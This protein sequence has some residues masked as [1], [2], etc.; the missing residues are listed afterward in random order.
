MMNHYERT[1]IRRWKLLTTHLLWVL[2]ALSGFQAFAQSTLEGCVNA[3][4]GVD[5]DLR[6][7]LL[8]FGGMSG[9]A[10]TEDWFGASGSGSYVIDTSGMGAFKALLQS[11]SVSRPRDRNLLFQRGMRVPCN[12]VV[13]GRL[14]HSATYIREWHAVT[15]EDQT[16]FAVNSNANHYDATTW[17]VGPANL[18]N[19]LDLIDAYAHTRRTGNSATTD[20]WLFSG[21]SSLVT[22][23]DWHI[24][25]EIFRSGLFYNYQTQSFY[26]FGPHKGHTAWSFYSNGSVAASGDMMITVDYEIGGTNPVAKMYIWVNP[27]TLPGGSFSSYNLLAN[28]VFNFTGVFQATTSAVS[29]PL[30]YGYAE[31]VPLGGISVACA[32]SNKTA[33]T[34]GPPLGT[35]NGSLAK[36]ANDYAALQF[37]EVGFNLT[38]LKMDPGASDPCLNGLG[39]LLIKRRSSHF[40]DA[41]LKDFVEP[42]RLGG[43]PLPKLAY[44]NPVC[45]GESLSLSASPVTGATYSWSGP[46]GFTSNLQNP[47]IP[48]VTLAAIG[49][50]TCNVT[51]NGCTNSTIINVS[52]NPS[53][54]PAIAGTAA[55][56]PGQDIY[57]NENG[58]GGTSWK[59]SGPNG[60]NINNKNFTL[61]N[62]S[63][64]NTGHYTVT[65]TGSNGCTS[66]AVRNLVKKEAMAAATAASPVVCSG[67]NLSLDETFGDA[68]SWSWTGP[69]GFASTIKNPVVGNIPESGEGDYIVTIIDPDGCL[70]SD[71]INIKVNPTP[72][73]PLATVET[74]VCVNGNVKL[75]ASEQHANTSF[76]WS[77]PSGFTSNEQNPVICAATPSVNGIYTVTATTNGCTS[78]PTPVTV[79]V[80]PPLAAISITENSCQP[81]DGKI[82]VGFPTTLT[83]SVQGGKSPYSYSWAN[84]LGSGAV[85]TVS[86]AAT[87]AYYVTVTDNNGCTAT[88]QT[89]VIVEPCIELSNNN[90]DDDGDGLIDCFDPDCILPPFGGNIG[91]VN[92]GFESNFNNWYVSGS[93]T[94]TNDALSGANAALL[95]D[96]GDGFN[97]IFNITPGKVYRLEIWAKQLGT[98][99]ARF[100]VDWLNATNTIIG[101]MAG[102]LEPSGSYEK[103]VLRGSS[104]GGAVKANVWAHTE[105]EVLAYFDDFYFST[106]N[107]TQPSIG[108]GQN[109]LVNGGFE[110]HSLSTAFPVF[111]QGNPAALLM[112]GEAGKVTDWEPDIPGNYIFYVNDNQSSVNNPDGNY[113]IWMP[114]GDYSLSSESLL[115][116]NANLEDGR[117]YTVSFYAAPWNIS[118]GEDGLP[119]GAPATQDRGQISLEFLYSGDAELH[120]KTEWRIQQSNSWSNLN[121]QLLTYNFT[122]DSLQPLDRI[123]LTVDGNTGM[124]IDGVQLKEVVNC[125]PEVCGNSLDDDGDGLTDCADLDCALSV[126]HL[127]TDCSNSVYDVDIRVNGLQSANSF[128]WNDVAPEA[129]WTFENTTNDVSGNSH[130]LTGS[131][132]SIQ[133]DNV[134]F[135]EGKYSFNFNGLTRLRYGINNSF[136]ENPGFSARTVMFWIKPLNLTGTKVLFEHGGATNG[137]A[138]R[139]NGNLLEAAVRNGG[140]QFTT[141]GLTIPNDGKWHHVAV[142]FNNGVLKTYLDGV[143]GTPVTASFTSV[144]SDSD[145]DGIGARNGTDAF[146]HSSVFYYTGRMD[147][148]RIQFSALTDQQVFDIARNDGDRVNLAA[149][150]Y[151]LTVTHACPVTKTINITGP[152]PPAIISQPVGFTECTGGTQALLVNAF[153]TD[154]TYQWQ[155]S[156][157]NVIF[158]DIAGA[159]TASFVPPSITAGTQYYR[160]IVIGANGCGSSTSS[161]ATVTVVGD[162]VILSAPSG[163]TA[164]LGSQQNLTVTAQ[165][166]IGALSYQWQRSADNVNFWDIPGANLA[167]YMPLTGTAGETW[168]RVVVSSGGGGCG[169]A[170]SASTL[171]T[172]VNGPT[173]VSQPVGYT[174]CY[175]TQ[176]QLAVQATGGTPF[177]SY[178]WQSSFD[179]INFTNI[180]GATASSYLSPGTNVGATYFRVVLSA[181]GDACGNTMSNTITVN[182]R[183]RVFVTAG[184]DINLC[185]GMTATMTATAFGNGPFEYEWNQGLGSG[186]VKIV[187]PDTNTV[188]T[189]TATDIAGCTIT[190]NVAVNL[191]QICVED[192]TNGIDDDGDGLTDCEDP[193]CYLTGMPQ[194][195]DDFYSTCPGAPFSEQ[196]S[197]N[198]SNLQ[199]P[200]FS[201]FQK[202]AKGAVVINNL[203]NF[204]YT[205]WFNVCTV[206]SF[207]YQVCNLVTGCCNTATVYLTLGNDDP[208]QFAGVPADI[209][210]ACDDILPSPPVVFANDTCPGVFITFSETSSLPTVDACE[211]Y[212]ITRTWKATDLCGNQGIA[213]QIITVE[214]QASPEIFRVYTLTNGKKLVAGVS[215]AVSHHWKNVKFP[216]NF[217]EKPLLLTQLVSNNEPSAASVQQRN[218]LNDGFQIRLREEEASNGIH[219]GEQVAWLA[220][221][222]GILNDASKLEAAMALDVNHNSKLLNF[223]Q[224]FSSPP[225]FVTVLQT[226]KESDPVTVRYTN[227]TNSSI[228]IFLQ[229]EKSLDAETNHANENL[230]YLAFKTGIPWTDQSG[231]FVAETGIANIDT[232]WTTV[233]LSGRFTKPVVLFGGI[234]NNDVG[235]VTVRVR[236]VT[237]NSFEVR[238]L[239]WTYQDGEHA[240]E[241]VSYIV[242]EGSVSG[243]TENYCNPSATQLIPGVNLFVKDNCDETVGLGYSLNI[244]PTAS[245]VHYHRSWSVVD[246]CGNLTEITRTDTCAAAAVQVKALLL[247]PL[248]G[249]ENTMLMSDA[250]SIGGQIPLEEPFSNLGN[251][252]HKG[253]GGGETI[254]SSVLNLQGSQ[255]VVDWILAE[256]RDG[257][258]PDSVLETRSLLLLRNGNVISVAGDSI[259]VFPQLQEGD[260]YVALRHRNH[261][262]LMNAQPVYL[263]TQAVP[264]LDFRQPDTEVNGG[265]GAGKMVNGMR[266]MWP[267]DFNGDRK[268]VYQGPGNDV[269]SLLSRVISDSGN[270]SSLANYIVQGYYR[271]D[272]NFDGKVIFQGPNNDRSLLLYQTILSHPGNAGNL[273]NF[274]VKELLP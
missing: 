154:L 145:D 164:C 28:R 51:V 25:F 7:N 34:F 228:R 73:G 235:A 195:Q 175:G 119:S 116:S 85:K 9:A 230:A 188:Y 36:V 231:D 87:S 197:L 240:T 136:L 270:T 101:Y 117:N 64:L 273:A 41:T 173:V 205:P 220:I 82:V 251:F 86:P 121:W 63:E 132:G 94:I 226:N 54:V 22:N 84:G 39:T 11:S 128:V 129:R 236:N 160:V 81:N 171:V 157:D 194:L 53:P 179:N 186:Q 137:L 125:T 183:E 246:E 60:F 196:V 268:I 199:N 181:S 17:V 264:L 76:N 201:I 168:Y 79:W 243:T 187:D 15:T 185:E 247:G 180:A 224:A 148:F 42:I 29:S 103:Y 229:E 265:T 18:Q 223:I 35:L 105:G 170:V 212:S 30:P 250:L 146:G 118:L 274:I 104:P 202:P 131:I 65:V 69:Q 52:V 75:F 225:G 90:I 219:L 55:I 8:Q 193:D 62:A 89:I 3:G 191:V 232:N 241:S 159:T 71:T 44:N 19:K 216:V 222:P 47:V 263:T 217:G 233:T 198:D 147:D 77:A 203:G 165:G 254:D 140:V 88:A 253:Q 167:T 70:A 33:S 78:A 153:G 83:V 91:L 138:M 92:Q 106:N 58:T 158:T 113:F 142:S 260:Y 234:S 23:G 98:E 215:K 114:P 115:G 155:S 162:P 172:V 189:V 221:E 109:V 12:S 209:T 271:E 122:Y 110:L 97:Q 14:W 192:C 20:L 206:D 244:V 130:H 99:P 218:I 176:Q 107:L 190:D 134:N 135:K 272:L 258:E 57:L 208:P 133:Y 1:G 242:V 177:L 143:P 49:T 269:F 111:L 100:G 257:N 24:D 126:E 120:E 149:G 214:D 151:S 255:A 72:P 161:V 169:T 96:D 261:L 182:I 26:N 59:W 207:V 112:D 46:N 174:G 144:S 267:G 249:N 184:Q 139:M 210:L 40:F 21:A 32:I 239:E 38:A 31:V 45:A 124:A 266:V 108:N 67:Q 61:Y 37:T 13:N 150:S 204:T 102:N 227:K 93:P 43:P 48:N 248:L 127:I 27:A 141:S 74:P 80:G 123:F 50:Y 262:G 5:G 152:V 238:L 2:L 211:N 213:S 200:L 178:Q 245:G 16:T 56:C 156:T 4:F 252:D 10:G 163:F 6:A 166:G 237:A 95:S 66:T 259:L 68:V 256:I